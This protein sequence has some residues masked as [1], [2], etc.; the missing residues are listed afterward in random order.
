MMQPQEAFFHL[1]IALSAFR[2]GGNLKAAIQVGT[3]RLSPR[4]R[5]RPLGRLACRLL[6]IQNSRLI[7]CQTSSSAQR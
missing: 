2:S 3:A 7:Y 1:D 6:L 4:L 5:Q